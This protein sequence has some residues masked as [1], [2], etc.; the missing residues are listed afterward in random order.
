MCDFYYDCKGCGGRGVVGG[1]YRSVVTCTD[2]GGYGF[3]SQGVDDSPS[4]EPNLFL[5]F[6]VTSEPK[7]IAS[8]KIKISKY[9]KK[10]LKACRQ[11][12]KSHR[13]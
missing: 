10:W 3:K 8:S 11:R 13:V 4:E 5:K 9:Q 7:R 1:I 2:C 6:G 12:R